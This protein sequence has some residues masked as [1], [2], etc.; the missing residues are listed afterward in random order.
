MITEVPQ[1]GL[2]ACAYKHTSTS[3]ISCQVLPPPQSYK[4]GSFSK[5]QNAYRMLKSLP[6]V[7]MHANAA[8]HSWT[9]S[10]QSKTHSPHTGGQRG[11]KRSRSRSQQDT[12][13]VPSQTTDPDHKRPECQQHMNKRTN[14]KE[15]GTVF[16][17]LLTSTL[18]FC[19]RRGLPSTQPSDED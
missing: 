18:V 8:L 11:S 1:R 16:P 10:P 19:A 7:T 6:Q 5:T 17:Q 3:R 14:K 2:S 9:F 15:A 4:K 12:P 13:I